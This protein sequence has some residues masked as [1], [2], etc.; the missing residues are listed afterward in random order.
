MG[1]QISVIIP[2]YN[3]EK[4]IEKCLNSVLH[5]NLS[6]TDYEIVVINDGST[7]RSKELLDS[8]AKKNDNIKVIHQNNKGVTKA[9]ELGV[10]ISK[11][12]YITFVDSDDTLPLNALSTFCKNIVSG[13]ADII[14]GGILQINPN[15]KKYYRRYKNISLNNVE[16]QKLL[17]ERKVHWGPVARLIKKEIFSDDIFDLPNEIITGEDAIM[18]IRLSFK[19][20]KIVFI[21]EIVYHYHIRNDS[22]MVTNSNKREARLLKKFSDLMLMSFVNKGFEFE[23]SILHFKIYTW[24]FYAKHG[25]KVKPIENWIDDLYKQIKSTNIE[26]LSKKDK[27]YLW[28]FKKQYRINLYYKVLNLYKNYYEKN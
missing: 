28:W 14:I 12:K 13:K 19:A 21:S 1:I 23:K 24:L 11:G 5:Q 3:S 9:R 20:K 16:Y 10:R 26:F 15:G 17:L 25:I 7:D 18:N 22:V 8:Y 2:V 6:N 27:F 4:Y